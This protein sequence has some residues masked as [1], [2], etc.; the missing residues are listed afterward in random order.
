MSTCNRLELESLGSWP[1]MPKNLP[2]TGTIGNSPKVSKNAYKYHLDR[3]LHLQD[4]VKML[5][6]GRE[7]GGHQPSDIIESSHMHEPTSGKNR[8]LVTDE[9]IEFEKL[10]FEVGDFNSITNHFKGICKIYLKWIKK[11]L[12][13]STCNRL[14]L[15]SVG[16]WPTLPKNLPGTGIINWQHNASCPR[17]LFFFADARFRF[18]VVSN[19]MA[20]KQLLWLPHKCWH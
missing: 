1:T 17:M 6:F 9:P 12:K 5:L 16:S 3:I 15:E 18:R 4:S 13:M 14:N 11:N 20:I 8:R 19:L 2:G 7:E 10:V